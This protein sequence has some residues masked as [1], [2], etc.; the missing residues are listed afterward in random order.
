L[1]AA[2]GAAAL[3]AATAATINPRRSGDRSE[4][5]G[6]RKLGNITTP[7]AKEDGHED[8]ALKQQADDARVSFCEKL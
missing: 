1:A 3:A 4:N 6:L 5:F 7:G 8:K 2:I